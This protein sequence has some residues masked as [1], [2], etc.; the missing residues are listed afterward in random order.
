MFGR[1]WPVWLVLGTWG[2]LFVAA[3]S[4]IVADFLVPALLRRMADG[5]GLEAPSQ[6]RPTATPAVIRATPARRDLGRLRPTPAPEAPE[7][8][9]ARVGPAVAFP[10]GEGSFPILVT[11]PAGTPGLGAYDFILR[12]DPAVIQVSE[13]TSDVEGF[14]VYYNADNARGVLRVAAFQAG[15]RGPTGTV[16]VARVAFRTTGAVG[17]STPLDLE[18]EVLSNAL[19]QVVGLRG[20]VDGRLVV[21]GR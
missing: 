15:S 8:A 19:G 3:L 6:V 13:V 14:S 17:S 1:P 7:T 16:E 12:F 18:V 2:L 9:T 5:D 10:G 21:Q 11:L 20:V 4:F